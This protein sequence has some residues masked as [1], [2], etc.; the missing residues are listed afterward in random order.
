MDK[1]IFALGFFDGVHL[2]HQALLREC[3]RLAEEMNAEP[4]A[5]TFEK[6]PKALFLNPP[7]VLLSTL[8][9]RIQMLR[10]YGMDTVLVLPVKPEVMGQPWEQFLDNLLAEG[11]V[12][13]VCGDD[14]RFGDGGRGNA[15]SLMEFCRVR[16]LPCVMV[17]VQRYNGDRISSTRIRGF[18]ESGDLESATAYLGHGYVVQV[19]ENGRISDGIAIPKP[20]RYACRAVVNGENCP[21]VAAIC[22]HAPVE[23]PQISA[24]ILLEL[25]RLLPE[26]EETR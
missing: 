16:N 2:G 15:Q 4:A 19:E 9:V 13:F 5:I 22:E 8:D 6:H 21:I 24:P 14:F 3:V 26:Q 17:E 1:R 25:E 20:G 12:G 7:P 23:L 11:A 10:S 18:I